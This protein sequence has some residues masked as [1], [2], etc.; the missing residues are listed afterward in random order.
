MSASDEH[1]LNNTVHSL[2]QRCFIAHC[3]Q[4]PT[5]AC[6]ISR[7]IVCELAMQM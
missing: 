2:A 3:P 4:S 6:E 7:R 1:C 5:W